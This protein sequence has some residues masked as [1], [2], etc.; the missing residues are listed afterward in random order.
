MIF[1]SHS[2][3]GENQKG[4]PQ[5]VCQHL[6]RVAELARSYGE[7]FCTGPQSEATALLH[8]LGKYSQQFQRRLTEPGES[9]RDHWSLGAYAAIRNMRTTQLLPAAAIAG[10]HVGL[11]SIAS[12]EIVFGN[13]RKRLNSAESTTPTLEDQQA[14]LEAF[15][16][17]GFELPKLDSGFHPNFHRAADMLDTRM[18]FSVLVDADFIAT[19]GHFEGDSETP[20]R[21]RERGRALHADKMLRRLLEHL[22]TLR[23]QD[24]VDGKMY[25]LRSQLMD[26]CAF[27]GSNEPTGA[28]T[29][30]APTGCGKT[31]AMLR[32]AIE[33]AL[34]HKL[35]RIVLVMPF[36]NIV[37][38]TASIYRAL[39]PAT[40]FGE[41]YVLES[42]SLA[43]RDTH[44]GN[45][46]AVD[47]GELHRRLLSQNWDAP[48]VLTTNVGL[49]ESLHA[50]RPSRCRK[51]HRLAGSVILFD[52]VQTLPP[53][54][55]TLTLATLAR[56]SDPDGPF[57]SSIVF[58]TATQPAFE[59]LSDRLREFSPAVSSPPPTWQPSE[60]VRD[61]E[62]IYKG[63]GDRVRLVWREQTPITTER[64]ADELL[65]HR[66]VAAIVNLKRHATALTDVLLDHSNTSDSIIHLS[67]SMCAAHRSKKLTEIRERLHDGL[68][69]RLVST[70]CIEAGVDVDFPS[71]YRA[72][73]P[74]DSI[75]QA[76]GRCNRNGCL[77]TSEVIVFQLHDPEH[78]VLYPP[79]YGEGID[80]TKMFLDDLR[81]KAP[82]ALPGVLSD[83]TRL[84]SYFRQ[85]YSATGRDSR[86]SIGEQAIIK[87][88]VETNFAD[89]AR[90]YRLINQDVVNVLVPFDPAKYA[91]LLTEATET[92]RMTPRSIRRWEATASPH[93]V[94]VYTQSLENDAAH[95]LPISFGRTDEELSTDRVDWWYLRD[96]SN[97]CD[98]VGLQFEEQAWVV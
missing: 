96:E 95:L 50:H 45:E 32:F 54:L 1:Y 97:Y 38:Q 60:I 3:N 5:P 7:A 2:R 11:E 30:T 86:A 52:E 19:E 47:P 9:S 43:V 72:L 76:A 40:E 37:Q 24:D 67:T 28:F 69:V 83:P 34:R 56:L 90:H 10:H 13:L 35:R 31:L 61:T 55:A 26:D 92:E 85:F 80:V 65:T 6:R 74:L 73:A 23:G 87:A 4:R 21:P 22:Q 57:H 20:Y 12:P 88:V 33:H 16:N 91:Q 79:G 89:V 77:P 81:Q 66:Q 70:Q 78:S 94:S 93:A 25:R 27:A 18:L 42:H 41:G 51:L 46:D 62:A 98:R 63:C 49:L 48:V 71:L 84:R 44:P 64:L 68:P 53:N 59:S 75:A 17:D 14:A 8:D 58:A 39:F 36:I 82:E 29:L 15:R